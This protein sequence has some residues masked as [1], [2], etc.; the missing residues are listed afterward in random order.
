[1]FYLH[2]NYKICSKYCIAILL[3]N[4][5]KFNHILIILRHKLISC[6]FITLSSTCIKSHNIWYSVQAVISEKPALETV[7]SKL[8]LVKYR[9]IQSLQKTQ[10]LFTSN[11]T[12]FDTRCHHQVEKIEFFYILQWIA[13]KNNYKFIQLVHC[14]KSC[15]TW[16]S[17]R[18][19]RWKYGY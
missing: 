8:Q 1:M 17:W 18:S 15:E 11:A 19:R 14:P 10:N 7:S 13:R 12:R 9:K 6:I 5:P 4:F 16:H 3:Q 2:W